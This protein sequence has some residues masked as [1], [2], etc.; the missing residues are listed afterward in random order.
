MVRNPKKQIFSRQG[1]LKF[2]VIFSMLAALNVL[3]GYNFMLPGHEVMKLEFILKLKIKS[4]D[5]LHAD[6]C[7]LRFILSKVSNFITSV[8]VSKSRCILFLVGVLM[9]VCNKL[10]NQPSWL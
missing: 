7:P 10:K 6:R 5:W 9:H 1:P 8:Q 4:N 3:L 2:I